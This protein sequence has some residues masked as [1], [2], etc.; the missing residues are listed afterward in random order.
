MPTQLA[1]GISGKLHEAV[2]APVYLVELGFD[3]VLRLSNADDVVWDGKL[4]KAAPVRVSTISNT[5][6]GGQRVS[7]TLNNLDRAFGALVLAQGTKEREARV[8]LAY[9]DPGVT[10]PRLMADGFMDGASVG[11]EV[12]ISIVARSTV[13]GTTPRII[14]AP[15]LMNHLP[16]AGTV[17]KTGNTTITLRSR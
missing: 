17:I 4:W 6:L 1:G 5:A 9:A 10:T 12:N 13:Y 14:C 2:T 3:P 7:L 15:P 16:Q 11:P 8:W